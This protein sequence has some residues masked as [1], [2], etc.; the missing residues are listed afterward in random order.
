VSIAR[1]GPSVQARLWAA[2][3][4]RR[5]LHLSIR[6]PLVRGVLKIANRLIVELSLIATQDKFNELTNVVIFQ[7]PVHLIVRGRGNDYRV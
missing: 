3:L 7:Y 2:Q 4:I 6:C 1:P 5:R